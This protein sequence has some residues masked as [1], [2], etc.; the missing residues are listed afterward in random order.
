MGSILVERNTARRENRIPPGP[1]QKPR[2]PKTKTGGCSREMK[3]RE[4]TK[5]G[6]TNGDHS[7]DQ[8]RFRRGKRRRP[9]L[10]LGK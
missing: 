3:R 10:N 7:P 2:D 8:I 9:G 4:E 6:I 1:K 5:P